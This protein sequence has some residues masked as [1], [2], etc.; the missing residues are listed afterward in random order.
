MADGNDGGSSA[1]DAAS[2][3]ADG[4]APVAQSDT[5]KDPQARI[6]ELERKLAQATGRAGSTQADLTSQ[7]AAEKAERVAV[8]ARADA[9]ARRLIERDVLDEV[10]SAAPAA[11]RKAIRLVA[12]SLIEKRAEINADADGTYATVAK[13]IVDRITADAPELFKPSANVGT[14][15]HANTGSAPQGG[16]LVIG[17]KTIF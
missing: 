15:P 11:T 14:T 9:A 10:L 3:G 1:G 16:V 17:G 8:Q 7:L 6:A 2:G 4:V 12:G 5:G 13:D